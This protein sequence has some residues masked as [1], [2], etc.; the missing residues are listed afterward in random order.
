MTE[1]DVWTIGKNLVKTLLAAGALDDVDRLM[2]LLKDNHK[3]LMDVR[4]LDELVAE[5]EAARH[6]K[7]Q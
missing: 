2:D 4:G 5:V 3:N 6:R 1:S 7:T